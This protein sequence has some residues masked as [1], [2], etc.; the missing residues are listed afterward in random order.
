[1]R[2]ILTVL[3][4]GALA[5]GACAEFESD[6]SGTLDG[7]VVAPSE[8]GDAVLSASDL[9]EMPAL[10]NGQVELARFVGYADPVNGTMEIQRVF[11]TAEGQRL[12]TVGQAN[13]CDAMVVQDGTTG[14]NPDDTVELYTVDGSIG[15]ALLGDAVPAECLDAAINAERPAY[16]DLYGI[17]G[18]FCATVGIGNFY[19]AEL[20]NVIAEITYTGDAEHAPTQYPYGNAANPDDVSGTNRPTAADGGMF[21]FGSLASAGGANDTRESLWTFNNGSNAPFFFEGRI[22]YDATEVCGNDIDDDCDGVVDNDCRLFDTGDECALARDC[23]SGVCPDEVCLEATCDDGVTNGDETGVDC[24]GSCP[25]GCLTEWS[26]IRNNVDIATLEG[27]SQCHVSNMYSTVSAAGVL[28]SCDGDQLLVACRPSGSGTL[29]VAAHA[30]RDTM[31]GTDDGRVS[32]AGR[33]INGTRWYYS[34]TWSW[35]FFPDGESV[36][37]NSCDVVNT[38]NNDRL[39]FHS[40]SGNLT[41][42]WRCGSTQSVGGY[43][44]IIFESGGGGG[45]IGNCFDGVRNGDEDDVDCGGALC[46]VCDPP[47]CDDGVENG[48]EL[49]IDCG[50]DVCDPCACD[51]GVQNGDEVGVDCG[52]TYCDPCPYDPQCSAPVTTFTDSRRNVTNRNGTVYCDQ[53]GRGSPEWGGPGWYR[54]SGAAGD[55][56]PTSPPPTWSCGTHA[57][58]WLNGSHP[59]VADGI[60]SRQICYHWSG[61]TCLWNDTARVVNCGDHYRYEFP[62]TRYCSL[63]YCGITD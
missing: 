57:P 30:D 48:D 59:T 34:T 26:G 43:E 46:P 39:C 58:G 9:H 33:L 11:E 54:F 60:V 56:M 20:P 10:Q 42:G 4:T 17:N 8:I 14:S 6:D 13:W 35:G 21:T 61:N 40:S 19:D 36:N 47:T 24:G 53:A 31:V 23:E 44:R 51:D 38:G 12:R 52:G 15:S 50:G 45:G 1:M 62:N 25:T 41:P 37:R 2:R 63:R 27:W 28:T 49:G 16:D 7:A 3:A 32:S 18:V 55:R 22:T 29:R 5:M